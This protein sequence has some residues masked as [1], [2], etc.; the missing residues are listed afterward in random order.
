MLASFGGDLR[1]VVVG[2]G[3]GIGGALV[4]Q[5]RDRGEVVALAR[6]DL[7]LTD[8]ASIVAAAAGIAA[9]LDLVIVA[10]GH[11]HDATAGPEKAL[12]DL[13][14]A[15]LA[16][17]FAVNATGPALAAQAFLPKLRTDRKTAFVAL[18]AR[19]GSIGDNRL[20]GWHGYRAS[21]AALNQLLRTIAIEHARRA[22][23]AVVV[24]LHPGTVDTRLSAPFQRGVAPERLFTADRSA[25]ALLDVIDR[26][27]P[28]RQRRLLRMGRRTD[29]VL[30]CGPAPV[31][32][33]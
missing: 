16:H 12:R 10:T 15:R 4:A 22:P 24:A 21:K 7:D 19:V 32:S 27:T 3:G 25:A 18:S 9:P 30:R 5:L 11:L 1:A 6:A 8:P 2:A 29:S 14:A 31:V 20:G 17:S 23:F 28:G 33:P 26:L 13:D